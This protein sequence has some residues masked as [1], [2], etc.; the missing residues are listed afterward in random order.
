[1][2]WIST[3]DERYAGTYT[4]YSAGVLDAS[5]LLNDGAVIAESSRAYGTAVDDYL[6][7]DIDVYSLGI[8][9]AGSY[10][11]DVDDYTWD[12]GNYD[13]S[14]IGSFQV[15]NSY[16]YSITT[17]PNYSSFLDINFT[18]VS[19][20]TYYVMVTGPSYGEAQYSIE[21]TKA[22]AV[23]NYPAISNLYVDGS[24][25]VGEELSVAGTYFDLNGIPSFNLTSLVY[26]Y[27]MDTNGNTSTISEESSY[28]YTIT[29]DDVGYYVGYSYG[30]IDSDGFAE[31][32]DVVTTSGLVVSNINNATPVS[33]TLINLG[34]TS[35]NGLVSSF[36]DETNTVSV[37][38]DS[39]TNP[40]I[41]IA[42]N[43]SPSQLD[44]SEVVTFILNEIGY[45]YISGLKSIWATETNELGI[46]FD[47][48]QVAGLNLTDITMLLDLYESGNVSAYQGQGWSSYYSNWITN[49]Q[50]DLTLEEKYLIKQ[51]YVA[52]DS[53][54]NITEA[55]N[56]NDIGMIALTALGYTDVTGLG[57]YWDASTQ[58]AALILDSA[59][60]NQTSI[61][62]LELVVTIDN[63][64]DISSYYS[65]ITANGVT[66]YYDK[67]DLD[68]SEVFVIKAAAYAMNEI[69]RI[70][71]NHDFTNGAA[72][73]TFD[74]D[75][76]LSDLL[77][78]ITHSDV[79]VVTKTESDLSDIEVGYLTAMYDQLNPTPIEGTTSDDILQ[80]TTG[81]DEISTGLG[82]DVVYALAGTDT[83]T[84]T[85]DSVW[86]SNYFATNISNSTAVGT[87]Q[88]ISLE[89]LNRFS[90]VIDGGDDI[91][92]LNLTTG[93]DAFFIDDV[94][95]DHHSSLTLSST[96]RDIDST[97]RMVDLEVINAGDG[98]DIV[99][100][101]SDSF[102]LSSDVSINGE[103]GNDTLWG[104]NGNDTLNGGAGDDT[105]SGGAGNDTL[106]GGSG[107][108]T[109]QFT[110]TSGT[111][112]ITDFALSEDVIQLFYREQ[113]NHT[114]TDLN[115]ANGI[116]TWN[117]DDTSNDVLI[118]LS[119]TTTS[120]DMNEVESLISF[121]EIV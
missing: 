120:S 69:E 4:Q 61:S 10:T 30:F 5:H 77:L 111:D 29:S 33:E 93:N 21:Y 97:A 83:I 51:A 66:G 3:I 1:M 71:S 39:A 94:Y 55:T 89:G 79:G 44:I 113:D 35:I 99:D 36:N 101:T 13:L 107:E 18:V 37:T 45:S 63:S 119:A 46:T 58:T 115:L 24:S 95:S 85:A 22:L 117:V 6:T 23:V 38:F 72:T 96:T 28:T 65:T 82:A 60:Y 31:V 2:A 12:W 20:E 11:V 19:P 91:D 116:L 74:D 8:L 57:T 86:D 9:D 78:S 50:D 110:A 108:D 88:S 25:V 80:G 54:E 87:N 84:L 7:A 67:Y 59:T 32:L 16:G 62:L 109:F 70:T 27:R 105:I 106:T 52:I 104:S 92:T 76:N 47:S 48:A 26:W 114:S 75:G 56:T 73:V 112:V 17:L 121:V 81:I 53:L 118:D 15:L 49:N 102:V 42:D 40:Y 41:S 100:L 90:D 103:A 64:G 98:N 34:F 43:I 14:S 68:D